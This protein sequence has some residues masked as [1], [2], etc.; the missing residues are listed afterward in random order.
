MDFMKKADVQLVL[1]NKRSILE[2]LHLE[3]A[4]LRADEKNWCIIHLQPLEAIVLGISAQPE[5]VIHLD[6]LG[7][8]PVPLIK[9]FSGGGTVFIDQNCLMTTFIFNHA[10]IGVPAYPQPV[11]QWSEKFYLPL[12]EGLNFSL[13]ENDYVIDQRKC[14]GNAQYMTKNRWLHHTSFLWDYQVERMS[15]LKM[16]PKMPNYRKLREHQEFL[17]KLQHYLP[18][19]ESF[20]ERFTAHL[21]EVFNVRLVDF[22][23]ACLALE[24][25]HR[26][27]TDLIPI[28]KAAVRE[29][30]N[31]VINTVYKGGFSSQPATS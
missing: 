8:H 20:C 6:K 24:R 1:L 21:S 5:Q 18:S 22:D 7:A 28:E 14:G 9:R 16:P 27:V 31:C 26:R 11:F 10:D 12:F 23:E 29:S 2:Q 3:E 25:P 30:E 15:Y 4:L 17:C 13:K 19:L